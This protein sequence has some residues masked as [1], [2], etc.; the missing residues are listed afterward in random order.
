METQAE[1]LAR[2]DTLA[3]WLLYLPVD[4]IPQ[5]DRD[6]LASAFNE[7]IKLTVPDS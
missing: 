1:E 2:K 6:Q 5:M 7:V 3:T 4:Q